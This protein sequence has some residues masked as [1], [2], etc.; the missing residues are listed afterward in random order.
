[1][2][3]FLNNLEEKASLLKNIAHP[4]RL[5]ILEYLSKG[6]ACASLTN[7]AIG[8]SQPNLSQHLKVLKD[9]GLIDCCIDGQRRCYSIIRPSLVKNLL[10]LLAKKHP[11]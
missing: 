8:I 6:P 2:K 3:K 1:M 4:V 5:E 7:K 9:V 11:V 10:D